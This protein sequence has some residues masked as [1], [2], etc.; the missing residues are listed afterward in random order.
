[1]KERRQEILA[2]AYGLMG[3]KGLEA[4]HAR[5]VATAVGVNHATVHYYFPTRSDLLVGIAEYAEQILEDDRRRFQKDAKTPREFV[6]NEIALVEAYCRKNS[7]FFKVLAGLYVAAIGEP[8]VKKRL[9]PIWQAFSRVVH[10]QVPGAKLKK[11]S[12]FADPE[13]LAETLAG[14]GFISHLL[15]GANAPLSRLDGILAA[16]F[17]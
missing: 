15:D 13:L 1:M 8:A 2:A 7:R 16:T 12:P 14:V 11:D 5:T 9:K 6:E 4:V 17:N 3:T 10:E